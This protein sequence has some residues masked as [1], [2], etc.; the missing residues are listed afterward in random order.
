MDSVSCTTSLLVLGCRERMTTVQITPRTTHGSSR[1][2]AA[3][4][5]RLAP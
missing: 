5:D 4:G 2:G 3:S 1:N